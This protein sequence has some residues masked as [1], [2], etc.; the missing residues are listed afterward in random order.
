MIGIKALGSLRGSIPAQ[1]TLRGVLSGDGS[2]KGSICV[3]KEFDAYAGDYNIVPK[4]FISQTLETAN[5][6]LKENVTISEVPYWETRNES[7]GQTAYIA[8]EVGV[9]GD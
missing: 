7:N 6:V 2:L 8:K 3:T 1:G 4:A 5:K 9:D